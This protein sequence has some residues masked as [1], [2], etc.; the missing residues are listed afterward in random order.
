MLR[1][2]WDRLMGRRREGIAERETEREHMS[3]AERHRI[4][5]SIED[6][7]ADEFVGEHLG[8]VPEDQLSGEDRPP[9]DDA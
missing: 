9:R 6:L 7:Q 8:G 2:L 1:G 3:P 5:E 4:D